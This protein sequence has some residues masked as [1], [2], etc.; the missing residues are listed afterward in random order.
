M[1]LPLEELLGALATL[2]TNGAE[3]E[4]ILDPEDM[5]AWEMYLR[6]AIAERDEL[7]VRVSELIACLE[8]GVE[9]MPL[10]QLS[11]WTGV[12]AHIEQGDE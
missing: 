9:L 10:E 4:Y 5:H 7:R 11:Q 1:S 2:P 3:P 8:H 12:R 6:A